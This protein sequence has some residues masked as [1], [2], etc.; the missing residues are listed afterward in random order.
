MKQHPPVREYSRTEI[1]QR[2]E[3]RQHRADRSAGI[4]FAPVPK[5]RNRLRIKYKYC[6]SLSKKAVL[7]YRTQYGGDEHSLSRGIEMAAETF[8]HTLMKGAEK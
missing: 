4:K 3:K 7:F 6:V 8:Y 1:E 5:K 2:R